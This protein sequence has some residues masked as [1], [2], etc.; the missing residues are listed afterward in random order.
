MQFT[1]PKHQAPEAI[2]MKADPR[3]ATA[4]AIY[5]R[6]PACTAACGHPVITPAPHEQRTIFIA[7]PAL[8]NTSGTEGYSSLANILTHQSRL[9]MATAEAA[10]LLA[11]ATQGAVISS[12]ATNLTMELHH[13]ISTNPCPTL[14]ILA[15]SS[16]NTH[17]RLSARIASLA[18]G[19]PRYPITRTH[20][21]ALPEEDMAA[22]ATHFG[23]VYIDLD[24]EE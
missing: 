3:T 6:Q 12:P 9:E 2:R 23:D 21:P 11:G 17:G 10:T 8:A 7:S 22:E 18:A 19:R 14:P 16:P 13:Q 15:M 20:S 24:D 4:N 5:T 1:L